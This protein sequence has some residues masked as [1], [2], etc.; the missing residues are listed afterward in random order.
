M[1]SSLS[2]A[3]PLCLPSPLLLPPPLS[4]QS[5]FLISSYLH[6][7]LLCSY[8]R[9]SA[10]FSFSRPSSPSTHLPLP[11][12][13]PFILPRLLPL[14]THHPSPSLFNDHVV[15]ALVSLRWKR[16]PSNTLSPPGGFIMTPSGAV[17]TS[18]YTQP[19]RQSTP[20]VAVQSTRLWF[21]VKCPKELLSW[22]VM[23]RSLAN[24]VN[25]MEA[26]AL[27]DGMVVH[28]FPLETLL[29]S[30]LRAIGVTDEGKYMFTN[31]W[32]PH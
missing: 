5:I 30:L 17:C 25:G 12:T 29:S 16:S 22:T 28:Y 18:T 20:S 9:P 21:S 15:A 1:F 19:P 3:P 4:S 6:S 2:F 14:R 26:I 13:L 8:P 11:L 32:L 24:P 23:I 7:S 31:M 10:L 27:F